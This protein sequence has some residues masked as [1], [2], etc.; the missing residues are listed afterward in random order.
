MQPISE[1]FK[2]E[3]F[4]EKIGQFVSQ[5]ETASKKTVNKCEFNNVNITLDFGVTLLKVINP[6]D[7]K[8]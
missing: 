8:K 4:G 3:K 6:D 1:L 7:I 5:F 2:D